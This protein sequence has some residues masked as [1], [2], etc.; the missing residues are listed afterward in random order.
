MPTH[1]IARHAETT[2]NLA[3]RYQGRMESALSALGMR[4]AFALA[5]HFSQ[6]LAASEAVPARVVSSPLLRCHATALVVASRLGIPLE[7]D[8]RLIEI[9]HGT[10]DGRYRDEIAANDPDRYRTWRHDPA[11]A[12]FENGETLVAVAER[13]AAVARDMARWPD[14]TLVLTHD[15]V[16]RCALVAL[17]GR[18]L[19][20]FW[21]VPVE[22]AAFVRVTRADDGTLA[23]VDP[24][25]TAHLA[26]VRADTSAQAL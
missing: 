7:S 11:R 18:P 8:D 23:I 12:A 10:W 6:A 4:Q 15:A 14:D 19:E 2:W 3:G 21:A 9:A 24:C 13:W 25:V 20:D 1:W 5:D 22:N 16:V 17:A 26:A